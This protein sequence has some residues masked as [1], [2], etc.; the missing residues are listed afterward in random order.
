MKAKGFN[1]M[2]YAKNLDLGFVGR[3]LLD[4]VNSTNAPYI[5][6]KI[7]EQL[8]GTSVTVVLIGKDTAKS[9]W[10]SNEIKWSLEKDNP[11]GLVGIRLDSDV[12]IPA[13]LEQ[14]GAEIL[15]WTNPG[16]HEQ[17]GPAIERAALSAGR[18]PKMLANAGVGGNCGR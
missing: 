3:H 5:S 9:D 2:R 1:L 15:D 16:D 13:E 17:F 7:K 11:N 14:A 6:Q 4:P 12:A 8:K 18:V 10:V